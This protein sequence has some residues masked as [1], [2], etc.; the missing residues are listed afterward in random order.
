MA[1]CLGPHSSRAECHKPCLSPRLGMS[2]KV[3]EA[4]LGVLCTGRHCPLES[5]LV[6]L[7]YAHIP[8]GHECLSWVSHHR[9]S[10]VQNPQG[11]SKAKP[12]KT[13][14]TAPVGCRTSSPN[15]HGQRGP[16]L[17]DTQGHTPCSRGVGAP[18]QA[19][20]TGSWVLRC[21]V[22]LSSA[23]NMAALPRG[24]GSQGVEEGPALGSWGSSCPNCAHTSL[25]P[26]SLVSP[27]LPRPS[28]REGSE[29]RHITQR[30]SR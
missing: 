28:S 2:D 21:R 30:Q 23:G 13:D 10:V 27:I 24:G 16:A 6:P 12:Q 29:T 22:R 4:C 18:R 20:C 15:T 9:G 11:H 17:T 1:S 26:N 25:W 3:A 5:P 8:S 19:A 14:Q 7:L